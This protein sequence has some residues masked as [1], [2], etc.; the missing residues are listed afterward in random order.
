M[1]VLMIVIICL[2][3]CALVIPPLQTIESQMCQICE[4]WGISC[5]NLSLVNVEAVGDR[6]K[7][8]GKP[9]IIIG[10]IEKVSDLMVQRQLGGVKLQ[11]IAVDEAQVI[12]LLLLTRE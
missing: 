1:I 12:L 2:I 5:L 3:G 10:S 9:L 11:Y 6:I 8:L 7:S 4:K